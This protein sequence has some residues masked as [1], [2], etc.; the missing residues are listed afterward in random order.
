MINSELALIGLLANLLLPASVVT[1]LTVSWR[2]Q[3]LRAWLDSQANYAEGELRYLQRSLTGK[4]LVT[5]QLIIVGLLLVIAI[6]AASPWPVLLCLGVVVGPRQWLAVRRADRTTRIE[7]QL[8]TWLLALANA[9][10]ASP[11]LG[12][13]IA[14][15]ASLM[16]APLSEELVLASKETS[17]GVPLDR[18]LREMAERIGSPVFAAAVA[19]LRIARNSGGD[20]SRT[21]ESAAASLREM[22]RLEGVVRTKTAEGRAQAW[23]IGVLP[24]PLIY[25]LQHLNPDLL[26]PLWTTSK[27]H[28]VLG[29]AALL[30][31][32]ALLLARK[33]VNVDV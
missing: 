11:S 10:R 21:L 3:G 8:D 1:L 31:A 4:K 33:I 12:D 16:A 22:A 13:A 32:C 29:A 17:L 5:S 9:L 23:V 30:W 6:V 25:M 2:S 7:G 15:S 24:A 28:M 27:G 26:T 14:A 19:T 18:A 20:L